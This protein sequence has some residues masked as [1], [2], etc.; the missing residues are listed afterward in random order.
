[1]GKI[2]RSSWFSAVKKA[3]RAPPKPKVNERGTR[4][5]EQHEQDEE[6]KK[7]ENRKW[8]FRRPPNQE[9]VIQHCEGKTMTTIT[10][11]AA[12]PMARNS[13]SEAAAAATAAAE[14]RHAIALAV[15]SAAAAEAAVASAQ[16]AVEVVRLIRP[17][18]IFIENSAAIV[19][20]TAFRGYLVK[21]VFLNIVSS[22]CKQ[23]L[24]ENL[25]WIFKARRALRALKG[26]VKLQA[27]VRGRNVRR[28]AKMTLQC[29]QTLLKVQA[30]VCNQR[31]RL[32]FEGSTDLKLN[33]PNSLWGSH[34]IDKKSIGQSRDGSSFGDDWDDQPRTVQ[35]IQGILQRRTEA[36]LDCEKA[37]ASAFSRQMWRSSENLSIGDNGIEEIPEWLDRWMTL[38]Q[39][40]MPGRPSTHQRDHIKTVEIDTA[41]PYSYR[42]PAP[43]FRI[44][45]PQ[46]HHHHYV[47]FP[48]HKANQTNPCR[49]P[50]TPS[51]SKMRNI[52]VHSASPSCQ[53]EER[54]LLTP[55]TP[56]SSFTHDNSNDGSTVSSCIAI[57]S[58]M[59]ATESA[60][61]RARSQSAPRRRASTP[62]RENPRSA[63]K[64]LSFPV[65]EQHSDIVASG[66]SSDH[67]LNTSCKSIYESRYRMEKA[68]NMSCCTVDIPEEILV[69]STSD[70]KRWLH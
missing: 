28:R 16:A 17:S 18:K 31:K 59:A 9:T 52:Q 29:M 68:S 41:R 11:A 45:Q 13:V 54:S 21:S 2:G 44:S 61:A 14:Q 35:E 64:R 19:I 48:L 47:A 43:D 37:L 12:A 22:C 63:R 6:E 49:S 57:P 38:K 33:D 55:H 65:P 58:Y 27:L 51:P 25:F 20:Q 3:F 5:G 42:A 46:Y 62:D 40:Q 56:R 8:I 4:K 70:L 7:R 66:Y 32:S 15:A 36:A 53:R 26:L 67:T 34:F 1:M 24:S 60:K 23:S 10:T 30:R 39:H 50:V 69:P